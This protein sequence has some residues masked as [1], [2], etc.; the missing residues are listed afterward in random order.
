MTFWFEAAG[1]RGD[2]RQTS[3]SHDELHLS[4]VLSGSVHETVGRVARVAGAMTVLSKDA[5]LLH[6]DDFGPLGAKLARLSLT[7]ATI[8]Q[9]IDDP[10]PRSCQRL[11]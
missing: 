7:D 5:G 2:I 11:A 10:R 8:G 9:L 1:Y 4:I 3:H 6:A